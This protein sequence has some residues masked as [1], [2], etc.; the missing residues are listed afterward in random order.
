[1]FVEITVFFLA[2]VACVTAAPTAIAGI[3]TSRRS[4]LPP[5][6]L[7][8]VED[9]IRH[10]GIFGRAPRAGISS[11]DDSGT[12]LPHLRRAPG[13]YDILG[14][15]IL[16]HLG[17]R[18]LYGGGS[19]TMTQAYNP[20]GYE[21]QSV[22]FR[23]GLDGDGLVNSRDIPV[24]GQVLAQLQNLVDDAVRLLQATGNSDAVNT[25]LSKINDLRTEAQNGTLGMN[26]LLNAVR[27]IILSAL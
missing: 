26:G 23:R 17:S 1:M 12:S 14:E 6:P 19:Q 21:I 13:F 16:G 20:W 24:N 27:T 3:H 8:R 10:L 25:L 22:Q 18:D 9:Q 5:N 4:T 11:G 15:G 2:L 7:S